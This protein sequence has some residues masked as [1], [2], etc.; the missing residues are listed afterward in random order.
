MSQFWTR[1]LDTYT[2]HQGRMK[3]LILGI[4]GIGIIASAGG[5][6]WYVVSDDDA[7]DA[8]TA[9][10]NAISEYIKSDNFLEKSSVERGGYVGKLMGRYRGM[11][12]EDRQGAR[13]KLG[14]VFRKDRKLERT[15][16][17]SFASKQA[18]VYHKLR[19]P[20][21]KKQFIDRWFTM[22]EMA[23]GGRRR[24]QGEYRDREP[25]GEE[26]KPPSPER[27]KQAI[28]RFRKSLPLIMSKTTA[29]DRA[30]MSILVRDA[31][32]RMRERYRN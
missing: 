10:L 5:I 8:N 13:E 25:F 17:I 30:K 6:L 21:E 26:R 31:A 23:H 16:A 15:V 29:E 2:V 24:V 28:A 14:S 20:E 22:M 27:K 18:D 3:W 19:T 32:Q 1:I 4:C 9:D 7:P 11:S 12:K